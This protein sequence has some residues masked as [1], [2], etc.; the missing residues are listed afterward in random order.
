[1]P[2]PNVVAT[3]SV[4][5]QLEVLERPPDSAILLTPAPP[6]QAKIVRKLRWKFHHMV[7]RLKTP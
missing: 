3:Y 7:E 2:T 5:A 1:M 4:A 6:S